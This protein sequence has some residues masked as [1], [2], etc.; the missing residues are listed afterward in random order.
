MIVY[1][2]IDYKPEELKEIQTKSLEM[3]KFFVQ[4]CEQH[5][6]LCYF[7]GG[8]CIGTIRHQ[9]FIPWDDDLD[10]FMPRED[11][12]KLQELWTACANTSRYQL[13]RPDK[14]YCDHNSMITIKDEETTYIKPYQSQLDISHGLPLDIFPLDG[15]P[16]SWFKRKLQIMYAMIYSLFVTQE[17][18]TKHGKFMESVCKVILK[19]FPNEQTRYRIWKLCEQQMSKYS[20]SNCEYTTELCAGPYY[21]KKKYPTSCF[22]DKVYKEFEGVMM[23]IPIGYDDYL[24]IAFGEYMKLPSK[25]K[26]KAHHACVFMD[27]SSNYKKYKG[28]Y[29]CTENKEK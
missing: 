21:M 6:L 28:I 27:L 12:E 16:N 1:D 17:I 2:A 18:P 29:Y 8:G 9:G 10:F 24:K 11:Y 4:F 20:M 7:C 15:Y 5:N 25:D 23:P 13:Y 22:E 19:S 26:Q 3:A 14:N